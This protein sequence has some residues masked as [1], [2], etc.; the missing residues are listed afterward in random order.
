MRWLVPAI[1]LNVSA[2]LPR[3]PT[4]S[5]AMRTEKSPTR[6]A[7]RTRSN[8]AKPWASPWTSP[9][10]SCSVVWGMAGATAEPLAF[11]EPTTSSGLCMKVSETGKGADPGQDRAIARLAEEALLTSCTG[12]TGR[13]GLT[14]RENDTRGRSASRR[15]EFLCRRGFP[16]TCGS[17]LLYHDAKR[18]QVAKVPAKNPISLKIF[19]LGTDLGQA[20]FWQPP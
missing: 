16:R 3:R 8:S 15:Q 11:E 2:I 6:I 13:M 7:C 10:T 5:P 4:R 1:S 9:L 20:E 18:R 19:S 14:S 12:E 17:H